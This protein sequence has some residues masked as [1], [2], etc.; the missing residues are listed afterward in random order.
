MRPIAHALACLLLT[1]STAAAAPSPAALCRTA[2]DRAAER[3]GVPPEIL[4]AIALVETGRGEGP[5]PWTLNIAGTGVWLGSRGAARERAEAAI[6]G[7]ETL[8]DLGCFQ[9]N[10]HWHGA[11]FESVDAMLDPARSADY[12]ARFLAGLAA[13]AGDWEIAAGHYH[14][15]TPRHA[16]RYRALVAA[17]VARGGVSSSPAARP[18]PP[19]ALAAGIAPGGVRLGLLTRARGGLLGGGRGGP[20]LAGWR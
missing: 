14:S 2:A 4:R 8:V 16:R 19:P 6:A 18:E 17:A 5:W 7:G 3:H 11:A 1:V 12:A 13:E 9:L 20:L 15:R 10:Y